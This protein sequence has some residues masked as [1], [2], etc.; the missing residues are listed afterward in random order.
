V[1]LKLNEQHV[2][3]SAGDPGG[4]AKSLRMAQSP[5]KRELHCFKIIIAQADKF[6]YSKGVG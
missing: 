4:Y 3:E 2:E 6:A 5:S 1:L